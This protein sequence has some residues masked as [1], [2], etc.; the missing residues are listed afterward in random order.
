MFESYLAQVQSMYFNV[1][2]PIV[3]TDLNEV[4]SYLNSEGI[5]ESASAKDGSY[6]EEARREGLIS[7]NFYFSSLDML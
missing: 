1:S 4:S 3:K 5:G 7:S 2:D 6:S